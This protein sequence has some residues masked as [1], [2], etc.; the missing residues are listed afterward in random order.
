MDELHVH[1]THDRGG[2]GVYNKNTPGLY[3]EADEELNDEESCIRKAEE[4]GRDGQRR[5][6]I[7][8]EDTSKEVLEEQMRRKSEAGWRE[9][10]KSPPEKEVEKS[11]M[12]GEKGVFWW[13]KMADISEGSLVEEERKKACLVE[14]MAE[15]GEE[16]GCGKRKERSVSEE[17]EDERWRGRRLE[18][19]EGGGG[20][21]KRS[22]AGE[23]KGERAEER[24]YHNK[25][26]GGRWRDDGSGNRGLIEEKAGCKGRGE[27]MGKEW[28]G[29]NCQF[30]DLG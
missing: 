12:Y 3:D 8:V 28:R 19:E 11:R 27:G 1:G 29:G 2:I 5:G 22:A 24:E 21:R 26:I 18:V 13:R 4:R 15:E 14:R 10:V 7:L 23:N 9:E 25:G 17:G 16:D 30:G 20:K 6:G